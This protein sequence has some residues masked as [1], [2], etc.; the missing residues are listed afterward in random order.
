MEYKATLQTNKK[1]K[2]NKDKNESKDKKE[3]KDKTTN[4]ILYDEYEHG[5]DYW[6]RLNGLT[7]YDY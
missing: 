6:D 4:N 2:N 7:E 3:S 5:G 1:T